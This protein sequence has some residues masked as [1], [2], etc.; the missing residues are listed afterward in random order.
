[1][2]VPKW[3]SE[4]TLEKK[5]VYNIPLTKQNK[6]KQNKTKQNNNKKTFSVY[7][8]LI[9]SQFSC[10]NHLSAGITGIM[11]TGLNP[12]LIFGAIK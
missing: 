9:C 3:L 5:N 1:M 4:T 2:S 8:R 7:L 12:S 6:T 11:L 10:L